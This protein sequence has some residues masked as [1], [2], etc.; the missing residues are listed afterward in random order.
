MD[1]D[2]S[3]EG[4]EKITPQD[5]INAILGDA[6][7]VRRFAEV[8][9]NDEQVFEIE[10]V[11][12]GRIALRPT[13]KLADAKPGHGAWGTGRD[14]DQATE[15]IVCPENVLA[16][17]ADTPRGE[18]CPGLVWRE[19]LAWDNSRMEVL[20]VKDDSGKIVIKEVPRN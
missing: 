4:H 12:D 13:Y 3:R 20:P 7:A 5:A 9:Q 2:P 10:L 15:S 18:I 11:V 17:L 14:Y 8:H 6:E 19:S 1:R 16:V